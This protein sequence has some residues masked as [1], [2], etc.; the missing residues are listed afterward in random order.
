MD[1]VSMELPLCSTSI[2]ERHMDLQ[3]IIMNTLT[4]S[5]ISMQLLICLSLIN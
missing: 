3:A 4:I 1:I 2:M 5:L